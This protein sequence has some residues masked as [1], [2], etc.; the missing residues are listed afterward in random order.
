MGE[1]QRRLEEKK[2]QREEQVPEQDN[3]VDASPVVESL[4]AALSSFLNKDQVKALVMKEL[5]EMKCIH[6]IEML[7]DG[8]AIQLPDQVRHQLFEE[9]LTVVNI[10]LPVALI[11]PAGSGKSTVCEQIAEALKLKFF[12]QNGVTGAHELTG[13]MDA[14]GRYNTTPFRDAFENGGFIMVDEVDTSEAGALKWMNTALANG[15]AAFPDVPDPVKRHPHFRI[16]IAANT[17]GSGADRLYVGANQLDAS[18]LDRFVFFNFNY[19]EKMERL[20]GGNEVWTT[21]VQTLRANAIKAHARI[22][23]S[24]RAT[25]NGAKLLAAGWKWEDVED[26]T[27]WKGIDPEIKQR[28]LNPKAADNDNQPEVKKKRFG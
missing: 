27:I 21:R 26:R 1:H 3:G 4:K 6:Q 15:H 9:I 8:K 7:M 16:A 23:I 2:N 25:I 22:V 12:L 11:G 19:D 24:P 20:L 10:N 14:H 18:T 17:W 5:R 28:I 13:Y